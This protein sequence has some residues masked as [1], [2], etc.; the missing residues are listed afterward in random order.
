MKKS[1]LVIL[2]VLCFSPAALAQTTTTTTIAIPAGQVVAVNGTQGD[3]ATHAASSTG[4]AIIWN[5][6]T[7]W[8]DLVNN[9][10]RLKGGCYEITY[11]YGTGN[12]GATVNWYT[13]RS[14]T[15]TT[16]W[17]LYMP[18]NAVSGVPT[19]LNLPMPAS[20]GTY[21]FPQCVPFVKG[22]E[23]AKAVVTLPAACSTTEACTDVWNF[24][25][26]PETR[27]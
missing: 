4:L 20:A 23:R 5:I 2:I 6:K 8:P 25:M 7:L 15:S 14:Q 3:A 24:E 18:A 1:L 22:V 10:D 12:T 27:N 19:A 17:S 13:S 9:P 26:I 16:D 11:T 21:H